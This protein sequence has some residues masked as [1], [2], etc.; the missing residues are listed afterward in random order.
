MTGANTSAHDLSSEH[1]STS[2]GED[3][4]KTPQSARICGI[5]FINYLHFKRLQY[6]FYA[7]DGICAIASICHGIIP[8]VRPSATRPHCIKTAEHIIE[9]LSLS[10]RPII[11]VFRRQ[12]LLHKSDVFTPNWGA[13]YKGVA[14]FDKNKNSYISETV[15]DRCIFTI[16]DECKVVCTLSN[17]AAFDDLE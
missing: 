11:I 4:D 5:R 15:I 14:I 1:G 10:D 13:E 17:S 7:R 3:L 9:I 16:E 6:K 12:R 2:S 8:S